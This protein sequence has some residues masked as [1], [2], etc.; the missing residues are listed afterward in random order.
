MADKKWT[1]SVLLHPTRTD[2]AGQPV[3]YTPTSAAEEHLLTSA[4]GYRYKNN[5]DA[6]AA[7][8]RGTPAP[9]GATT[10]ATGGP[11]AS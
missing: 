10:T 4:Y 9:A 6:K 3:E 7:A 8:E 2:K 5:K 1:A 11:A